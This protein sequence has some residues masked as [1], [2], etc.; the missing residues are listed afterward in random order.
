M[1]GQNS[2]ITHRSSITTLPSAGWCAVAGLV[3]HALFMVED[4]IT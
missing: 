2:Y 4:I 1:G 3:P